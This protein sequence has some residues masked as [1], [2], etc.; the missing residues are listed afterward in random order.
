M[1]ST[2]NLSGYHIPHL[3]PGDTASGDLDDQS[4]RASPTPPPVVG[5]ENPRLLAPGKQSTAPGGEPTSSTK[6]T[7]P[8]KRKANGEATTGVDDGKTLAL[9][10]G[11]DKSYPDELNRLIGPLSCELCK[12]QMTSL[13]CA[14]DHYESK[15]HDRHISAWL[16]KN[17]TD[18]GLQAPPV[19]RLLKHGPSGPNAFHCDLCD[20]D[21]TSTT[22]AR[23]HYQGRK[24]KLVE[25]KG[26]RPS[27]AGY[28]DDAGKWVRTGSKF[29]P[30]VSSDTRYGIGTLFLKTETQLA[31]DEA[32]EVIVEGGLP[33]V[34]GAPVAVVAPEQPAEDSERSCNLCKIVVTS[35]NQMQMHLD[36]ARH[37]SKLRNAGQKE[38]PDVSPSVASA[39][40]PENPNGLDLLLY[41]T[42]TGQYYCKSCN[43]MMNHVTTLQ[44]HLVG[45]KHLKTTKNSLQ[46]EKTA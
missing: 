15:A 18:A 33:A 8:Q 42:P 20:L 30:K 37:Q 4:L 16:A 44:Q 9:F 24:H 12:A 22:H 36:G 19:K 27:G 35:A 46:A 23:Q 14:R 34:G 45:K 28:Y 10:P 26:S 5:A 17:Y 6:S 40:A 38:P 32:A 41:R 13:K 29:E 43:K 25:S 1:S 3:A 2:G 11:R 31:E 39:S 7:K 21:L